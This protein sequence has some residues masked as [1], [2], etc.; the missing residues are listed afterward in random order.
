MNSYFDTNNKA[1]L[2]LSVEGEI[3]PEC[4]SGPAEQILPRD[5]M[6]LTK[7]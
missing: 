3:Y 7:Q 4:E 6:E 2:F 1:R 5:W